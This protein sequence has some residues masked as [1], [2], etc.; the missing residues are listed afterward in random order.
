MVSEKIMRGECEEV[1]ED[2]GKINIRGQLCAR[3]IAI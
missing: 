2:K 1:R 3:F